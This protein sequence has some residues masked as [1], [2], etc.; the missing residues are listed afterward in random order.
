MLDLFQWH[1]L[2]FFYLQIL[3]AIF[4]LVIAYIYFKKTGLFKVN[5]DYDLPTARKD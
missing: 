5:E 1:E 3:F 4:P 2:K